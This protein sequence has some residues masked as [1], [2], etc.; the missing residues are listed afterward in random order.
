MEENKRYVFRL[1]NLPNDT[2]EEDVKE[3]AETVAPVKRVWAATKN[4]VCCGFAFIEV[5]DEDTMRLMMQKFNR[6]LWRSA[7]LFT[8]L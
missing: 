8:M 4:G 3:L 1:F 5:E 7:L 2:K 6:Y